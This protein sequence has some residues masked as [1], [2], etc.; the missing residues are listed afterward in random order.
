MSERKKPAPT[1]TI[2]KGC[3][4]ADTHEAALEQ[5]QAERREHVENAVVRSF[6]HYMKEQGMTRNQAGDEILRRCNV[7]R[8]GQDDEVKAVLAGL[9]W[10]PKRNRGRG[11]AE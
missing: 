3:R 1:W 4:W 6:V 7:H 2:D 9:R 8:Y 5:K 11:G 10:I